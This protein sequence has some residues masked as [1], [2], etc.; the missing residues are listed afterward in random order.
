MVS[1]ELDSGKLEANLR[2]ADHMATGT[3]VIPRHKD[4][5]WQKI[6]TGKTWVRRDQIRKL[7]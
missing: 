3:L 4:L 6:G 7:K 2:I 5:D 1:L